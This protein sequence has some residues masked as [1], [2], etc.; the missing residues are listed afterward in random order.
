VLRPAGL[1]KAVGLVTTAVAKDPADSQWRDDQGVREYLAWARQWYPQGDPADW[2]NV[3]GYS[4]SQLM[5]HVLKQCG[6][7]LTRENIM[8][9]A[10]NIKDLQLPMLLPGI[11]INTGP[12]DYIPV[13]QAQFVRFDGVRWVRFGEFVGRP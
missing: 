4:L 9:Q 6:D 2:A 11:K 8:R 1:E 7:E 10:T 13:E 5:V 12:S 3:L